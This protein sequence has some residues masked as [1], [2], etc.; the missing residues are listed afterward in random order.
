M[1]KLLGII[2]LGLM[3]CNTSY[4]ELITLTK[5]FY[6]DFNEKSSYGIESFSYKNFNEQKADRGVPYENKLVTLDTVVETITITIIYKDSFI[7]RM[8]EVDT[9]LPK[10]KKYI[11]RV[12]DLGGNV[13][14]G[15]LIDH[16]G[17][18][19]ITDRIDVDFVSNKVYGVRHIKVGDGE[20]KNTSTEQC[21]RQK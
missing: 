10:Y 12:V 3:L 13:A 14:T 6:T 20:I 11:Y 21:K 7:K 9:I 5:C 1:K 16:E 17:V 18:N 15:D 4:A 2:V 19:T 8:R